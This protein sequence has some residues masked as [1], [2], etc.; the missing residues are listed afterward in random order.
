MAKSR[1]LLRIF[2]AAAAGGAIGVCAVVGVQAAIAGVATAG[3]SCPSPATW[4]MLNGDRPGVASAA[5]VMASMAKKDVV[6]LGEQ[7]DEEDDHRWQLQVLAALHAQRPDMV[8]G[9]EMFPRRVQPVLDRWVAG[10]LTVR[11][12]LEQSEWDAGLEAA[13]PSSICRCSSSRASTASRWWRS[14]S[15]ESS[16]RGRGERLGRGARHASA[17]ASAGPRRV[18][19]LPRFPVRDLCASTSD[20]DSK[21]ARPSRSDRSAPSALRRGADDVG[22]RDGG[23]AGAVRRCGIGGRQAAGGR[24]HGQRPH[25]LRLRRAAPVARSQGEERRDADARCGRTSTARS[26]QP[27]LA[28][29]VFA[30]AG[31][32]DRRSPR[33]RD[34]ASAWKKRTAACASPTSPPAASPRQSGLKAGDQ[35][36]E[37]AGLPVTGRCGSLRT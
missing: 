8:I 30:L 15:T 18:A 32:G 26:C 31:T 25:P 9:F 29:A 22:P 4:T 11:Q 13:A 34:S 37:V 7:H 6:L 2:V 3:Q 35:L 16:Q 20:V 33:R 5:A 17:K 10:E 14:T 19:R 12:L 27:G 1:K 36:V 24:H 28:D 23:G 21:D